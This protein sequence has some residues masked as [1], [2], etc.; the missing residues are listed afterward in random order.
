MKTP[1]LVVLLL[2]LTALPASAQTIW[3]P[4]GLNM[5]GSWDTLN[6]Q[7][8][9]PPN[10]LA[11][12]GIVVSSG[13]FLVDTNLAVRRYRTVVNVQASGG[14]IVGGTYKWLFTSPF[15]WFPPDTSGKTPYGNKWRTGTV[16]IDAVQSYSYFGVGQFPA[17]SNVVT[18]ADG[19]YYTVNWRDAGYGP[20]SAI[21]MRTSGV[22]VNIPTVTQLPLPGSVND[23]DTVTVTATLS[24]T[25][26]AEQ[27]FFVR[28]TTDNFVTTSLEPM[29][30]VG[31]TATAKLRPQLGGTTVR[32]YV[33]SSTAG[34]PSGDYDLR[35]L[36]NNR[37]SKVWPTS[38]TPTFDAYS[39]SVIAS[40]YFITV[41][42][43]PNGSITPPGPVVSVLPNANI[44]FT[45]T[46]NPSY[47]VDSVIVDNAYVPDSTTSYTFLNVT[48]NHTI[49]VN[50]V[51]KVNVTYQV[52]MGRKMQQ[53]AFLPDSGDIVAIRGSFN[54]WG[55]PPTGIRD[56]LADANNDSIWTITKLL[57]A[58]STQEHKFWKTERPSGGQGYETSISNRVVTIAS[59]DT[60]IPLVYF[61]NDTPPIPVTFQVDMRVQMKQ[62]QFFPGDIVSVRGTFNGWG[63]NPP[64]QAPDTLSD[65]DN[66]SI[67]TVTVPI[68]SGVVQFYKFWKTT[69]GYEG[70]DNRAY[71]VP[72]TPSTIPVVYFS[73][74]SVVSVTVGFGGSW[75]MISNPV[76]AANDSMTVLYPASTLPYAF[77]FVPGTGYQ[78]RYQL[79][80]GRGYWGKF[81]DAGFSDIAGDYVLVD[82][83]DLLAGWN[84]LG[85]VSLPVDTAIITTIPPSIVVSPYYGYDGGYNA[86]PVLVPG[87][88]YWVK[89]SSAGQIALTGS[90]VLARRV[91][92]RNPLDGLNSV[93]FSDASGAA[94]TLYFGDKELEGR[95]AEYFELPPAGPEGTF[96]ARFASGRM[97][98]LRASGELPVDVRAAG[99]VS[100][101]WNIAGGASLRMPSG[102]VRRITGSG[103][104][105]LPAAGRFVI[106]L[107]D[108][109]V[110]AEFAL[111]QN[112]PNP[113]NPSTTISYALPVDARTSV[114]IFD[115]LGRQVAT[116]V[117]EVQAAGFRTVE[118][119]GR[120]NAG[121][122][123]ASGVY[124]YRLEASPV[125]GGSP[126]TSLKKMLLLK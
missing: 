68:G 107:E 121:L 50:F 114:K 105:R 15:H 52:H 99:D 25:P 109:G 12:A 92:T 72:L 1:L 39:Y 49:R 96:D 86:S 28:Y 90:P 40:Q 59:N 6:G 5:P 75:N 54:N 94:Q 76:A 115:L 80:N 78:Q 53:G 60:T 63:D 106:G 38:P 42:A 71:A 116:L 41:T 91:E 62:Y 83:V 18:L 17:D 47:Y 27:N 64:A 73:N 34:F 13:R 9:N 57:N 84:M 110:P 98:E 87:K 55:D 67:W 122:Q 33:F 101:S 8:V 97:A 118:W 79:E 32:Y 51:Q 81:A 113:F 3:P 16:T 2:V 19:N 74:D 46:P 70:G 31:T 85:S 111:S 4:E 56:T 10:N 100:V 65:L 58:N 117:D 26:P 123:V 7:W 48:A 37:S 125:A 119:N 77:A 30:V 36:T 22:P 69:G 14:D 66:D 124:F 21:W 95:S 23:F 120:N 89:T 43:G 88:G 104:L 108:A 61:D 11:F 103:S 45:I 82:T 44:T 29:T 102:E 20:T 93:T 126:F 24:G 112:Y 35:T